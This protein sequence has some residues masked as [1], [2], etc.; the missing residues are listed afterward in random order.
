MGGV[1]QTLVRL[2]WLI[3]VVVMVAAGAAGGFV[4]LRERDREPAVAATSPSPSPSASPA[5]SPSPSP[6]PSPL[7]SPSPPPPPPAPAGAAQASRLS[8]APGP[9]EP[10][11][12]ASLIDR[13]RPALARTSA[14]LVVRNGTEE[15]VSYN[16]DLPLAPASAQKVLVAA[17][18]LD[19]LGPDFRF[20]TKVVARQGPKD[21]A[22]DEVWLV[23][24][25]DPVLSAPEWTAFARAQPRTAR[26]AMTPMTSL[27]DGLAAAGVKM[28]R[29]AVHGDDSWHDRLRYLPS[30]KPIYIT[31]GDA[32]PMSGLTVNS[33]WKTWTPAG[34]PAENPTL[35]AAS[36]LARLLGGRGIAVGGADEA[37]APGGTVI[38]A[39]V[40]SPPLSSI[41]ASMLNSSDNLTAEMITRELGKR[42]TG[43]GSTAA[44][45]R[46]V[47]EVADRLG[48]PTR[49]MEMIDG[50][51]LDVSNRAT[52]TLLQKAMDLGDQAQFHSIWDGLAVAGQTG[53]L[54]RRLA[55]TP[56]AGRLHAKTGSIA[57]VIAFV[58]Y[59]DAPRPIHFAFIANGTIPSARQL[60]DD[61]L[62]AIAKDGNAA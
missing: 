60:G 27:V 35:Y 39:S 29:G 47:K 56:L 18:A 14:C 23:G 53:T 33:G 26:S 57:G 17:A 15:T 3:V 19:R 25:G 40:F 6:S 34:K 10:E 32:L 1:W 12:P 55:D 24:G 22:V 36:E 45:T 5:P 9:A 30:W 49:G 13:L 4:L 21:G 11:A 8:P 28:I 20:V 2:P 48:L 46:V 62:L 38:L 42:V 50:S 31:D 54:V 44:G 58:G 59:I 52:C 7:P 16:P 43:T 41:V 37:V 51:G 61:V